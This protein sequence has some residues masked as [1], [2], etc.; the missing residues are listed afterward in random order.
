MGKPSI[1]TTPKTFVE[2]MRIKTFVLLQESLAQIC[3]NQIIHNGISTEWDF[4]HNNYKPCQNMFEDCPEN[5]EGECYCK[6]DYAIRKARISLPTFKPFK[7]RDYPLT[8]T[9]LLKHGLVSIIN[10]PPLYDFTPYLPAFLADTLET[11][12][13]EFSQSVKLEITSLYIDF[14]NNCPSYHLIWLYFKN[15]DIEFKEFQV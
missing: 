1:Q 7:F 15:M 4:V 9:N 8:L 13:S 2:E 5:Q 3:N 6:L 10:V 11:I 12:I 14:P